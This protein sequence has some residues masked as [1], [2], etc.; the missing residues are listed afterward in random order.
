[1]IDEYLEKY[2]NDPYVLHQKA[3]SAWYGGRLD[4]AEKL[5]RRLIEMAPNWVIA[6]NQL[7]YI[8]MSQG[9]FA[10]AE[11]YFSSY[12]FVAP[13]Q[14]NPHDSL[15][16]L[17]I[18]TG[19]Y[20]EA[21]TSLLRSIEIRP[22]FWNAYDHLVLARLMMEDLVGAEQA[23]L[24]ARSNDDLPDYWDVGIGCVLRYANMTLDDRWNEILEAY[25]EDSECREGHSLG[26]SMVVAHR[27]A[28]ALGRM[29]VA[30]SIEDEVAELLAK[31]EKG[32][33]KQ[34]KPEVLGLQAHMR[35]VRLA[36][37]GDTEGAVES[38]ELG[39]EFFH[40]MMA[41]SGLFKLRNRLILVETLLAAG[42]DAKAHQLL[43]KVQSVNPAMVENFEEDGL[44]VLGLER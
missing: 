22:D 3:L 28:C 18:I 31:I 20:G 35:G 4:E 13:D 24:M 7:G 33:V 30:Q 32:S 9:R 29:D 25:A 17:Y 41:G 6:Y 26:Y 11:E 40:Y 37:L 10:E 21:E 2:P 19:R 12:R 34:E 42:E 39:D 44:K 43:S 15:G 38:F 5:N 16:E 36:T 27:A 8:A 23:L 14:A 1:M